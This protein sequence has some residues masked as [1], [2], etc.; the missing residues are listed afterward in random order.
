MSW[1]SFQHENLISLLN[2]DIRLLSWEFL[3]F[4]FA[5]IAARWTEIEDLETSEV[6]GITTEQLCATYIYLEILNLR[7]AF[8]H[9]RVRFMSWQT[10]VKSSFFLA[11]SRF[12]I[13]SFT[14]NTA[15]KSNHLFQK[16]F[17]LY[18]SFNL[19]SISVL[20]EHKRNLV[21]LLSEDNDK[22]YRILYF[23]LKDFEKMKIHLSDLF[24]G[25]SEV[26]EVVQIEGNV[27]LNVNFFK[28][29]ECSMAPH[30]F[31]FSLHFHHFYASKGNIICQVESGNDGRT[32]LS[33][34]KPLSTEEIHGHTKI[35]I[36][37][38]PFCPI[39]C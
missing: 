37:P 28:I 33:N 3:S 6:S 24:W 15:N 1:N 18:F 17:E 13:H 21:P 31:S 30:S 10:H 39:E 34:G 11:Q 32:N 29:L 19:I 25:G 38:P 20:L 23:Y 7:I 35:S 5:H 36:P 22:R 12:Q 14:L 4:R 8:N 2:W 26:G 27:N 9:L 16:Q